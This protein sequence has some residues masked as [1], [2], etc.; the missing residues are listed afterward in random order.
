MHLLEKKSVYKWSSA[1]QTRVVQG[2]T[3]IRSRGQSLMNGMSA[4]ILKRPQRAPLSLPPHK[5]TG[6]CV[7]TNKRILYAGILQWVTFLLSSGS[8]Q[9]R[10]QT[11]VSCIAGRFFASWATRE[12]QNGDKLTLTEKSEI[13]CE[14]NL[15]Q[16]GTHNTQYVLT[17]QQLSWWY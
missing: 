7:K 15:T 2:S 8:S 9:P 16:C 17:Q 6:S 11:Q 3:L 12:T 1:V 13:I 4:F 14:E 5:D 10:D